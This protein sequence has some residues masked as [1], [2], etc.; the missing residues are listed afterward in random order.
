MP[1]LLRF[2]RITPVYPLQQ[3]PQKCSGGFS[4]AIRCTGGNSRASRRYK[5]SFRRIAP[6]LPPDMSAGIM[7]IIQ[8]LLHLPHQNLIHNSG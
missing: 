3:Q 4:R 6:S 8:I 5:M 7:Q 1:S 2:R